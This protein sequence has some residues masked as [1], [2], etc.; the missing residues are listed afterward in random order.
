MSKRVSIPSPIETHVLM[1]SAR[2]CALCFGLD[3]VLDIKK[4]QI[5]HIDQDS[6]N[7]AEDNLA[8]L[9]LRHHDEYDTK[10]SQSKGITEAELRGYKAT[11]LTA[12]ADEKHLKYSGTQPSREEGILNHDKEIF[13]EANG[14]LSE[15]VLSTF[16][17]ALHADHSYTSLAAQPLDR[18]REFFSDVGSNY[19]DTELLKKCQVLNS[20]LDSLLHFLAIHF[21]VFPKDQFGGQDTRYCLYPERNTDRGSNGSPEDSRF[22]DKYAAQLNKG[23]ENLENS[24]LDYRNTVKAKLLV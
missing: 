5:A 17:N 7:A 19:I 6:S 14:I 22:Y 23:I 10:T 3:G 15:R 18:F 9:C 8:F 20:Q 24:Y 16:L 11:L 2:R 13:R 1:A 12:I 4:G 21:F